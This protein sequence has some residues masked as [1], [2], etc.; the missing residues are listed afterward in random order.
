M[1]LDNAQLFIP[2]GISNR[3]VHLS[4]QDMH[5][6]FGDRNDLTCI[7][8]ITQTGQFVAKECVTLVGLK[9]S[10][11]DVRVLGPIRDKTQIEITMSDVYHLGIDAPIRDSGD[12][13]GSPGIMLI[14]PNGLVNVKSGLICAKRH[15]HMTPD[16]AQR[17]HVRDGQPVSVQTNG[18]RSVVFGSVVIRVRRDYVLEFHLDTDEANAAGLKNNDRVRISDVKV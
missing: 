10:I 1:S 17:F 3:H 16:D 8:P 13:E 11:K 4:E 15:I 12:T 5:V 18:E 6:L 9:A 14:G 7:R 2:V